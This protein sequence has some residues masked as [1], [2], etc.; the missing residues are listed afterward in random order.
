MN[1]ASLKTITFENGAKKI[2][3]RIIRSFNTS[4]FIKDKLTRN[5]KD[6]YI[7][8]FHKSQIRVFMFQLLNNK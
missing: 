3:S 4:Y 8:K 1:H 2:D 5:N 7:K 6:S